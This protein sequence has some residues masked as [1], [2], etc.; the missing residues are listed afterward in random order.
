[1]IYK[2]NKIL[3]SRIITLE[4]ELLTKTISPQKSRI[5]TS[6]EILRELTP[7]ITQLIVGY[8]TFNYNIRKNSIQNK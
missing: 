5:D 6:L 8:F 7:A 3:E 4:V 2:E 1:M